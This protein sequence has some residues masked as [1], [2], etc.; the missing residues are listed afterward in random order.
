M[1]RICGFT[2]EEGIKKTLM[3]HGAASACQLQLQNVS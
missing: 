3:C 1:R 2:A